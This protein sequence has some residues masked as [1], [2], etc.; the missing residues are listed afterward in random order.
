M[1]INIFENNPKEF[2]WYNHDNY[3]FQNFKQSVKYNYSHIHN[4][5]ALISDKL[6]ISYN[7]K[8]QI[9]FVSLQYLYS[10]QKNLENERFAREMYEYSSRT[11]FRKMS[12]SRNIKG[13]DIYY[14]MR[15]PCVQDEFLKYIFYQEKEYKNLNNKRIR[16]NGRFLGDFEPVPYCCTDFQTLDNSVKQKLKC[17]VET[18]TSTYKKTLEKLSEDIIKYGIFQPYNVYDDRKVFIKLRELNLENLS[19]NN[20]LILM[21][22]IKCNGPVGTRFM[23]LSEEGGEDINVTYDATI[24]GWKYEYGTL[25]WIMRIPANSQIKYLPSEVVINALPNI[26]TGD[27]LDMIRYNFATG[28]NSVLYLENC[29]NMENPSYGPYSIS[30]ELRDRK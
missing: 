4:C 30:V 23:M 26:I 9:S 27:E 21:L 2:S 17:Q 19:I 6:T 11:I 13:E 5:A 14:T 29:D 12:N 7:I 16:T 1:E 20:I 8:N 3:N 15:Y 24:M 22:E 18:E 10:L 25:F 28:R